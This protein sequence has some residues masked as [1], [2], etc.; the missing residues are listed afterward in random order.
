MDSPFVRTIVAT[1]GGYLFILLFLFA[2][3]WFHEK[4]PSPPDRPAAL[5]RIQHPLHHQEAVRALQ[6]FYQLPEPEKRRMIK[7]LNA[8]L[9]GLEQWIA[10]LGRSDFDLLCMGEFHTE[11]TRH[12]LSEKVFPGL[13]VDV[14]M[15]EA[16][17]YFL[18]EIGIEKRDFVI[19]H[20]PSLPDPIFRWFEL[21]DRQIF[22]RYRTLVVFRSEPPARS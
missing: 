21:L 1:I 3:D 16:F 13:G 11:A 14:L 10:T 4:Y 5:E 22:S 20:T 19:L 7:A 2:Y 8:N 18:D 6:S 15:L 9:I 17:V 12:F